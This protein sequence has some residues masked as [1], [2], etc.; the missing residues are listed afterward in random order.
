MKSAVIILPFLVFIKRMKFLQTLR[1]FLHDKMLR[2]T[3][4]HE[5]GVISLDQRLDVVQKIVG[6]IAA[7]PIEPVPGH[8][9][10]V[11]GDLMDIVNPGR[12]AVGIV[13]NAL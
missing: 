6:H 7:V 5:G 4:Y 9:L 8:Q 3:I 13:G 2:K 10:L 1:S 12:A 11:V